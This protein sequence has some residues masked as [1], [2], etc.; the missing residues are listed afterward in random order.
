MYII[1]FSYIY[2]EHYI[3]YSYLCALLNAALKRNVGLSEWMREVIPT[4][5][6][7]PKYYI[8][9]IFNR[10]SEWKSLKHSGSSRIYKNCASSTNAHTALCIPST[11]LAVTWISEDNRT[12][13]YCVMCVY[14]TRNTVTKFSDKRTS[15]IYVLVY[16][17]KSELSPHNIIKYLYSV[18][19]GM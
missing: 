4:W 10:I 8:L 11:V 1:Y 3:Q 19:M 15:S 7:N 13:V 6:A 2:I 5:K 18:E 12:L 14:S 17:C 16:A 9:H